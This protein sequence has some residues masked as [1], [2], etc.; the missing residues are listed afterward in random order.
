RGLF[1][2]SVRLTTLLFWIASFAGL[3]LVYGV[4]TWLPTM[5]RG[6]GYNL[7]SAISFLL[8]I[9]LGGIVGMLIAG[10]LADRFGARPVAIVWFALTAGGVGL[11]ALHMPLAVTY[12]VVFLTGA[13]LFSAQ[14]LIYAAVGAYY[15]AGSRAPA[16]GWVSG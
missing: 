15:P 13:W 16:R 1:T 14:T 8:V 7:G 6:A 12:V 10:R 4:N 3:L 9:N 11:L 5:M 2:P